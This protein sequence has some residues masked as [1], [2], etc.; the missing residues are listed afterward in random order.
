MADEVIGPKIEEKSDTTDEPSMVENMDNKLEENVKTK[1]PKIREWDRGKES[2]YKI[3]G[4]NLALASFLNASSFCQKASCGHLLGK[5]YCEFVTFP[6]VSWVRCGTWLYRF[7][8][9]AP[10]LSLNLLSLAI[11]SKCNKSLP[12]QLVSILQHRITAWKTVLIQISQL[13]KELAD[14]DPHC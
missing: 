2:M 10:L 14:Q 5:V 8:I 11:F 7:Q 6:L 13:L 1:V 12:H 9:F 4:S 3:Q